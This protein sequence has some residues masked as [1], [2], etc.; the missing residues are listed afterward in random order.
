[1]L[2]L[3][4]SPRDVIEFEGVHVQ[5]GIEKGSALYLLVVA[6][7][8]FWGRV[9]EVGGTYLRT[10][11]YTNFCIQSMRSQAQITTP[12]RQRVIKLQM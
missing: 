9:F 11:L 12:K 6:M 1:M 8:P 10:H 4:E 5:G 7:A 3:E 2:A